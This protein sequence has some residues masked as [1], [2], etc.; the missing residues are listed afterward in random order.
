[1][2]MAA[3]VVVGHVHDVPLLVL[4]GQ[5]GDVVVCLVVQRAGHV[6]DLLVVVAA[7]ENSVLDLVPGGRAVV[8]HVLSSGSRR[9]VGGQTATAKTATKMM[10]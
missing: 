2:V 1:V 9:N 4:V 7:E 3:G 6:L 8:G 5:L 10:S